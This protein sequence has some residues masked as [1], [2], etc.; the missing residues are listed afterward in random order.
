MFKY[1]NLPRT[2]KNDKDANFM[3]VKPAPTMTP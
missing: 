2:K 3:Y 1:I